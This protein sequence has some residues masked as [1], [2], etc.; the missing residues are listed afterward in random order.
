MKN[1]LIMK[2]PLLVIL[3]CCFF[4]M[5]GIS[6]AQQAKNEECPFS[7]SL[8]HTGE[9]MRYWY[10]EQGGFKSITDIPYAEL[11]CKNC[12]INSCSKCHTTKEEGKCSYST[13]KAQQ[14]ETCLACHTRAKSTFKISEEAGCLDV[15][16]S[17]GMS[18]SDCHKSADVH[19]DGI[20][21]HS[22]RD[23]GAVKASCADCH[24]P[25]ED[26]IRA[27]TVHKGKLDC[28][29][30][31]ISNSITC[32]NC[33]FEN[34]LKTGTR[35]G[36]FISPC[37]EWVLLINYQGKVTTGTVQTLVYKDQKFVAYAPYFT[38]AVQAKGKNC[39]DCH[40]NPAIK[41]IKEGKNVSMAEFKDDQIVSYKGVVPL[42]PDQL[43][44][45]FFNKEGDKWVPLENKEKPKIQLTGHGKPLTDE[46]IK[47]MAR[48]YKK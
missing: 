28:A 10:E 15:H 2:V 48:P 34:F 36:N 30:C 4:L 13:E 45:P 33:H 46:Q 6:F 23:S 38:H 14:T 22:M 21:Y 39:V 3:T 20:F 17:S 42:V 19:G 1:K 41:L 5:N 18:C 26:E 8:H 29:A 16:I 9:G 37:Q 11:D 43:Q 12:H 31:H 44:W 47:K 25:Q 40:A 35:K 32:L 7:T 27:H 24:E